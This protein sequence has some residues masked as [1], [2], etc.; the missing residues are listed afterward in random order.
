MTPLGES[1]G[2]R[3][4][5]HFCALERRLFEVLGGWV[6]SVAEPDV[7]VLLRTH[8]FQHAW[9]A[10]LW[11]GLLPVGEDDEGSAALRPEVAALLE[12]V[13]EP[14]GTVERLAGAYRV[15]LPHLLTTYEGIRQTLQE[16]CD[17]PVRRVLTLVLADDGDA[18]RTGESLLT[19]LVGEPAGGANGRRRV[20]ALEAEISAAGG[21]D[22]SEMT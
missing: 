10:S 9:H 17:G 15:L 3:R 5:R 8:S 21:L 14:S 22:I 4:A 7:K 2:A 13:A 20:G 12:R 6:P 1:T 18:C 19:G 16:A 11:A